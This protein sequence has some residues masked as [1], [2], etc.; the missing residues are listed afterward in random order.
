MKKAETALERLRERLA[1]GEISWEDYQTI[2]NELLSESWEAEISGSAGGVTTGGGRLKPSGVQTYFPHL[3]ESALAPGALVLDQWKIIRELGRG[4]FGVVF[5]AKEILLQETH[6]IKVLDPAIVAREDGLAQFRQEASVTRRLKHPRIVQVYDYRE[7]PTKKLAVI[8]MEYIPG[9]TTVKA[10]LAHTSRRSQA[11]T[12]PLALN[13][14]AQTLEA[15]GEAHGKNVIHRDIM[16]GN[17]LLAGGS[18]ELLVADPM[19]DPDVRLLDFGIAV[20]LKPSAMSPRT[21]HAG[22]VGYAAPE[23]I[24]MSLEMTPAADLYSLGAVVYELLTGQLPL[25]RSF[26]S[27]SQLRADVPE[28][29]D[30]LLL[31]LLNREPSARMTAEEAQEA[32]LAILADAVGKR[33]ARVAPAAVSG[34]VVDAG[35]DE[36][37][38]PRSGRQRPLTVPRWLSAAALLFFF[39]VGGGSLFWIHGGREVDAVPSAKSEAFV[40]ETYSG[41]FEETAEEMLSKL[42]SRGYWA[43]LSPSE[44][45]GEAIYRVLV[46]PVKDRHD[47]ER[48]AS[49][50]ENELKV[51][52]RIV[53]SLEAGD[54]G[55]AEGSET[56][57]LPTESAGPAK[58]SEVAGSDEP[59]TEIMVEVFAINVEADA[60]AVLD[61][62]ATG[63][64]QAYISPLT[65]GTQTI[66]RVRMGPLPGQAEADATKRE[67]G[68]RFNLRPRIIETSSSE[69]DRDVFLSTEQR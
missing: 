14:M 47:A 36:I 44:E 19:R 24:D 22:T 21:P 40:I 23:Q 57:E 4:G 52:C 17:I 27:P 64:F 34:T 5:E 50:I 11:V 29:L 53:V 42:V 3:P 39:L 56:P 55:I 66:Y 67:V 61:A 59:S 54:S 68:E 41:P 45:D 49:D 69:N 10:L 25:G 51:N 18:A 16:P 30:R 63:G 38:R 6:A 8:S 26:A 46:G 7:D 33:T 35:N 48:I 37:T 1:D 31:A 32:V 43:S 15:L 62:L 9:G 2:K 28:A 20:L 13:V 58:E 65:V 12:I 60:Q